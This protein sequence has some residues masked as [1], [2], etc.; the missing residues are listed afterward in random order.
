MI[1]FSV[2]IPHYNSIS[3]LKRLLNSIPID[4]SIQ[5][6]VVDDQSTVNLEEIKS[7][8]EIRGGIFICNTTN[9]KGAGVCRNL[10]LSQAI[11]RWLVFADAD[12]YFLEGAFDILGKYSY[13]EEDIIYFSPISRYEN[14]TV[15]KRHVSYEKFVKCYVEMPSTHNE[16][17]L[18]YKFMTPWS[19]M[20]KNQLVRKNKIFFDEIP[21]SN[22]VMFSM[23]TA[24][25]AKK[26][27]ASEEKIYCVTSAKN[28]LTTKRNE[29]YYW[30][31]VETFV[32][33]YDFMRA[34]LDLDSHGYVLPMGLL[35]I[36]RAV[37]QRYS[38]TFV[39]KIYRYLRKNHIVM[40]SFKNSVCQILQRDFIINK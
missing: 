14:G 12:D 29:Q 26:I 5:L 15:A 31:R 17:I 22:D 9:G 30:A 27:G 36:I 39:Y 2:I 33:R 32:N 13:A 21:A 40:F 37:R 24:Y 28:T 20:I 8:I 23:K 19:K 35:V 10:G 1:L 34:H 18:R 3:L 11:G 4:E 25:C 6:I 16:M 7:L 38:P